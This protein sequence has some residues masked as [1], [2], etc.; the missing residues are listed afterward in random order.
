MLEEDP[1]EGFLEPHGPEKR[2]DDDHSP[3]LGI[4]EEVPEV[5]LVHE[6]DEGVVQLVVGDGGPPPNV[7]LGG[8]GDHGAGRGL[9]GVA[10]L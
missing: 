9:S 10:H 8:G 6:L 4:D 1:G 2:V 3:V 7:E 5:D